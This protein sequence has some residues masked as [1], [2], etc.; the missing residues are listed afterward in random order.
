MGRQERSTEGQ[1]NEWKSIADRSEEVEAGRHLQDR[2]I[3][4]IREAPRMT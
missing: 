3:R 2:D 4:G 1:E